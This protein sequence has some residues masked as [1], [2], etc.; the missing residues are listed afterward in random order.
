MYWPI[1]TTRTNCKHRNNKPLLTGGI[2]RTCPYMLHSNIFFSNLFVVYARIHIPFCI[3]ANTYH[4]SNPRSTVTIRIDCICS[5]DWAF[6]AVGNSCH[7]QISCV[8]TLI[9][10]SKTQTCWL[11]RQVSK[12]NLESKTLNR[13]CL[14]GRAQGTRAKSAGKCSL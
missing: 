2:L 7:R 1:H 13:A 14:A 3:H 10:T 5:V 11:A 8:C 9:S 12:Q 6:I 4:P